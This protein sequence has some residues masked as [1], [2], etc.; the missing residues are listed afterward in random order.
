MGNLQEIRRKYITAAVAL[1]LISVALVVYLQW[2]GSSHAEREAQRT[3]LQQRNAQLTHEIELRKNSDPVKV[4]QALDRFY[5][6]NIATRG[7]QISKQLEKL[8]QETGVTAQSIRYPDITEKPPLPGV[9][10]VKIETVVTGDYPK[11]AL[12][13]NKVEQ[14]KMLFLIDKVSLSGQTERGSVSLQITFTT[15]LREATGAK[16]R[17]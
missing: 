1:G 13:I 8:L 10:L 17:T 5:A 14:D 7:S 11:I 6:E 4:Q 16:A 15:F 12:F 2:P 9:Q 3:G